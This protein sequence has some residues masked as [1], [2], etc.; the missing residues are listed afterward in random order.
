VGPY[1]EPEYY[2]VDYISGD[3]RALFLEWYEEQKDKIFRNKEQLLAYCMDDVNVL[4][5]ACAFR[6]LF[7]KLVKMDP[8]RQAITISAICNKV[9]RTMFLKP[10]IVGIIPRG[11]RMGDRQSVEALEWLVYIGRTRDNVIHAGN[12]REV[13]LAR[14]PDVKVDG[15]CEE[16]NEV[17]EYLGCYHGCLCLQNRHKPIGSTEETLLSRY[18]TMARLQKIRDA[19]YNVISIWGY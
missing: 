7:L 13:H 3:E 6:N 15:Y 2:G 16:T 14:V 12:G 4:R 9:F 19:G 11:Y 10:D 18:E 8:F 5:Q 1:P 17:F